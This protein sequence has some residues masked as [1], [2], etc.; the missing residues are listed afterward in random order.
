V[1]LEPYGLVFLKERLRERGVCPVIYL[2]NEKAN[3][4][5]A[6]YALFSL[7]DTA[8]DAAEMLLPLV[9]VFGQKIQPPGAAARP[10]GRV[11]FTWEREWRYPAGPGPLAFTIEDVFCGLCPHDEI[12]DFEF[13]HPPLKFIDPRRNM[14]WYAQSLIASR[15]R[16]NLKYS[17]V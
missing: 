8:P 7:K 14:K 6:V 15:Q 9:A 16:H 10:P 4:D 5:A 3:I 1:N 2:N 12:N 13:A 11:D 17:V